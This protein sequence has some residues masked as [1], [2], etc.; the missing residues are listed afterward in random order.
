MSSIAD[1]A[2][3]FTGTTLDAFNQMQLLVARDGD[4]AGAA[5]VMRR[6]CVDVCHRQQTS[7]SNGG[8]D[9]GTFVKRK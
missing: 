5:E 9:S 4:V 3:I 7:T 1:K 6:A 8:K 2:N